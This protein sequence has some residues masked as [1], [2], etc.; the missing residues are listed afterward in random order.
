[1]SSDNNRVTL[2]G[3]RNKNLDFDIVKVIKELSKIAGGAG[4]GKGEV[5][6]GGGS[7]VDKI[8][9]ILIQAKEIIKKMI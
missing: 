5:A 8:P 9:D 3:A 6:I 4:G 2:V 1:M 7:A